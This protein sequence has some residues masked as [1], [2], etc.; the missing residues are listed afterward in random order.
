MGFF[1]K[2]KAQNLAEEYFQMLDN[3]WSWVTDDAIYAKFKAYAPKVHAALTLWVLD[4]IEMG[5]RYAKILKTEV[6]HTGCLYRA[7]AYSYYLVMDLQGEFSTQNANDIARWMSEVLNE[8]G[9]FDF[10]SGFVGVDKMIE[11]VDDIV[12]VTRRLE[13][14]G[15]QRIT[16]PDDADISVAELKRRFV[17]GD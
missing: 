9:Y 10:E 2:L 15:D 3:Y 11:D 7:V 6:N 16:L 13:E 17:W 1:T 12:R 4:S 8:K 5:K 14:W